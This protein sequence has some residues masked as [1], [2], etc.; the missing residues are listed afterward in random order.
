MSPKEIAQ[1]ASSRAWCT[2]SMGRTLF[3]VT[4]LLTTL[5]MVL[6][7]ELFRAEPGSWQLKGHLSL[8]GPLKTQ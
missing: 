2:T 3:S 1:G 5:H 4:V 7:L 8:V 6:L